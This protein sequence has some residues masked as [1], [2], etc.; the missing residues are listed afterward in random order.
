MKLPYSLTT[1]EQFVG[2]D[3]NQVREMINLFIE[4]IPP[5]IERIIKFSEENNWKEVYKLAHRIK[6]SFKVFAMEEELFD[7]K[8]IEHIAKENNADN[9]ISTYL[10]RLSQSLSHT[11]SLLKEEVNHT[12]DL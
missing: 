9:N 8:K 3:R 1:L 4:T 11:I 7:I 12:D 6:P 2:G 5:D 10:T